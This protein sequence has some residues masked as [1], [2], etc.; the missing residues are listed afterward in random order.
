MT[1]D[2]PQDDLMEEN[3]TVWTDSSDSILLGEFSA[4]CHMFARG[5]TEKMGN[6]VLR[7]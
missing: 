4:V 2:T 7:K 6:K 1:N 3:W 5:L